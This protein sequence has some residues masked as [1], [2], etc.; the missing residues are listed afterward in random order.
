MLFFFCLVGQTLILVGH[1]PMSDRYFKAW[2]CYFKNKRNFYLLVADQGLWRNFSWNHFLQLS[3]LQSMM[4]AYGFD[5]L[6]RWK[7][8]WAWHCV[9]SVHIQSYSGL[10][11]PSFGL[12]MERYSIYL[13]I[14][15]RKMR[16]R[17]TPNTDTFFEESNL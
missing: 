15:S 1:C 3:E 8:S 7:R 10:H 6:L 12:N 16:T 17:I 9:K 2:G 5:D 13:H 4:L 11:F 14:H